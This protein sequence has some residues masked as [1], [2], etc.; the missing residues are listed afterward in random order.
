MFLRNNDFLD[1]NIQEVIYVKKKFILLL[2]AISFVIMS[3]SC[4]KMQITYTKEFS[5]LPAYS[6]MV[7]TSQGSKPDKNGFKGAVYVVKN[8]IS[9]DVLKQ[10]QKL[11]N[12]D[13]WKTTTDN[14]PIDIVMDKASHRAIITATQNKSD[15][16]LTIVTKWNKRFYKP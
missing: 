13:G 11:L 10:Y 7:L 9:S 1:N 6:G 2:L 8:S 16:Y 15:A 3:Y 14:K 12:G 5:Y 4:G